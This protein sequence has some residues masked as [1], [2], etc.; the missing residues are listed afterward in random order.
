MGSWRDGRHGRRTGRRQSWLGL[1]GF[2]VERSRRTRAR[3]RGGRAADADASV[4]ATTRS[5]RRRRRR[6][7][8]SPSYAAAE[9]PAASG[10]G[11]G[12]PTVTKF[13]HRR[14][15]SP[16]PSS[17]VVI[18]LVLG[19]I[20]LDL[21][22]QAVRH[23]RRQAAQQPPI[24]GHLPRHQVMSLVPVL[25]SSSPA[26]PTSAPA[27]PSSPAGPPPP[28]LDSDATVW[29]RLHRHGARHPPG[30]LLGLLLRRCHHLQFAPCYGCVV[31]EMAQEYRTATIEITRDDRKN[32]WKIRWIGTV[33]IFLNSS[34]I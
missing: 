26:S 3:K 15:P 2:A 7:S 11:A 22:G 33:L 16:P 13:P 24:L 28:G 9:V 8:P 17:L 31:S 18:V 29:A 14:A 20:D 5:R 34:G 12:S 6:P 21:F 27:P 10:Q 19:E 25:S 1:A 32:G 23:R 30:H 4:P